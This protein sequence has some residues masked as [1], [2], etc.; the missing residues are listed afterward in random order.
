MVRLEVE[1]DIE[2]LMVEGTY[3]AWQATGDTEW[4]EKNLSRL[5][6][7]LNYCL[8]DPKGW[9]SKLNLMKRP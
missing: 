7:G 8:S 4:V 1:A 5:E 6:K 9:D 3:R 2:Y